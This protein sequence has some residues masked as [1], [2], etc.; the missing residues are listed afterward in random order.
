[1]THW[2]RNLLLVV[3]AAGLISAATVWYGKRK[4]EQTS[5]YRTAEVTRGDVA[6]TISATGTV[7]PEEVIDVG[8]QVAGRITEFGKDTSGK[9]I[10][11]GSHLS[12]GMVLALIDPT[13]YNSDVESAK[14]AYQSATAGVARAEADLGQFQAKFN[15]A[16]RDWARA[17]KLGPSDALSQSDYDMYESAFESAKANVAVGQAAIEQAKM[18]VTQ[19]KATLDRA[20]Q[21]L[22]YCTITSPVDGVIIDRRVNIGQTVVSSLSAPSLFLIA[23]DLKKMEIWASVNEADIGNIKSGQDV[24]FTVDAFPTRTFKGTV[25]KVRLNATMT[26]NVVTYTVEIAT[27]NSDSTLLPYLTANVSFQVAK[28]TN[29]LL[30]PNAALRWSPSDAEQVSPD[31]RAQFASAESDQSGS[32]EGGQSAHNPATQPIGSVATSRPAHGGAGHQ[33]GSADHASSAQHTRGMVWVEDGDFVKPIRVRLGVT[34][35]VNTEVISDQIKQGQEVV[36]GEAVAGSGASDDA[37]NPFAPQ[38]HH[39]KK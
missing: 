9:S 13:L 34:D 6:S 22:G 31:A 4:S 10:D 25:R 3:I 28:H 32:A 8:A 20:Q 2:I 1:M 36:T 29:V 19:A 15:Q 7:E 38:F 18:Q 27:D 5:E 37:R 14:A 30:V 39:R 23:Q 24:S 12:K 26:Q 17:Q 16:Q 21:N 11:Y 33:H 35:G